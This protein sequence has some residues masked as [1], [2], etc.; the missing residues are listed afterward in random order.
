MIDAI[1]KAPAALPSL[2]AKVEF[3]SRH[4]AYPRYEGEVTRR[5][6]HMSWVFLTA[7]RAHKL[8]K[9]VRFPYLDFPH[10]R[11]GRWPAEPRSGSTGGSPRV[12]I[13]AS[14]R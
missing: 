2:A 1:S 14:C 9:P 10:W 6:T 4:C 7:D 5:E 8:K 3:L 11:V 12:F 13:S